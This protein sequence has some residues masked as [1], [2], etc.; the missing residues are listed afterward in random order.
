MAILNK[1][2]A[3]MTGKLSPNFLAVCKPNYTDAAIV[4]T[5]EICTGMFGKFEFW[6]WSWSKFF[7]YM[8]MTPW[9]AVPRP[10]FDQ[11]VF[12]TAIL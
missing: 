8:T 10:Q 4:F 11:F 7:D 12:M 1:G 2:I 9:L 5:R 3:H 6:P